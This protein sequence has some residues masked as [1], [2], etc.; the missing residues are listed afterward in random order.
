MSA[1]DE[2]GVLTTTFNSMARQLQRAISEC[3][4]LDTLFLHMTDGVVAFNR[5]GR[6]IQKNPAAED[7]LGRPIGEET[8]YAQLFGDLA[9]MDAVLA[10][11]QPGYLG[12]QKA[13]GER[14]LELLLAPFD[15]ESAEGGVMVGD[16]RRHRAAQDGGDAPGIRGQRLPRTA[17]APHQY[18]QLCRDPGRR[19]GGD[20][21]GTWR[22]TSWGSSSTS[23]TA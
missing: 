8:T 7:M 4:K 6:V 3:N 11:P 15:Q 9:D 10:L 1:K 23:P 20:P 19:G 17:H 18:P 16:P 5:Q 13:V 21:A 2:I 14:S 22:R 12:G